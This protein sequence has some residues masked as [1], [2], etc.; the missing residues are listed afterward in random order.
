MSP[1]RGYCLLSIFCYNNV[2]PP[3]FKHYNQARRD[4]IIVGYMFAIL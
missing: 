4:D 3:G 2:I 1:L